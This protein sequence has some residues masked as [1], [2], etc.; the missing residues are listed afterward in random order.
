MMIETLETIDTG[1]AK[2]VGVKLRGTL[3]D[4]DLI[5]SSCRR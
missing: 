4:E 1:S 2:V 5:S 3:H